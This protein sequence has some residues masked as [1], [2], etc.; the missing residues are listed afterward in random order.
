MSAV[1]R[2]VTTRPALAAAYSEVASGAPRAVVPTMGA[3]HEGHAHLIREARD[4]VGDDGHVTVTVFVNP[5]QFAASDDL[6]RYPRSLESDA[7]LCA[8]AGADLVF[9][10]AAQ[11][12]YPD[13]ATLITVDPGTLGSVLEGAIR[14]GHFRGVLTVVA[15]LIHLT[16]AGLALFG[17]KDYQQLVL[18]RQMVRD[19]SFPVEIIGVPTV[20]DSD[21]LAL[22]SRN[23]YLAPA[24]RARAVVVPRALAVGT[25][26]ALAGATARDIVVGV[27]DFLDD[28]SEVSTDYAIVTDP[29]LGPAP[30][31]GAARLL[32]AVQVGGVRLLDNV[33]ITLT[34]GS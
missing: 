10:P 32:V 7:Q 25:E 16:G 8:E 17:E 2:V 14:P 34:G 18:V 13:G 1:T 11:V 4:R 21:G 22:S 27:N 20:R 3:L 31:E 9:A 29:E 23:A 12:I 6:D 15:K 19:L 30:R 33:A 28:Q 24:D 26:L 5:T